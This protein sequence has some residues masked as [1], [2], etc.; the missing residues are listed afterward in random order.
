MKKLILL[1][2]VLVGGYSVS[3][4]DELQEVVYLKNGSIVRGVIIEQI[5]GE[6]LKIQTADGS[7]FAYRISE[8]EKMTK[9]P[10]IRSSKQEINKLSAGYKGFVDFGYIFDLS[11]YDAGKIE[12][13]TSHGYQFNPY[14][15]LG[16][17][18]GLHYYTSVKELCVPLF[19]NVRANLMKGMVS[20]FIDGKVGYSLGEIDGFYFSPSIGCRIAVAERIG[21]NLSLGYVMQCADIFYYNLYFGTYGIKTEV[22]SGLS[23]KIGVDF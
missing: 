6:S 23:L 3:V 16:A 5:P 20:P 4:A 12:F 22:V 15:Y 19:A 13:M 21:I 11:D 10:A 9:E 2:L 18:V 7:I 14:F 8:V 1:L 17:G